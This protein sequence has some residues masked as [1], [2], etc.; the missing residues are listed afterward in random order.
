MRR[1]QLTTPVAVPQDGG[2]FHALFVVAGHVTVEAGSVTTDWPAGTSGL[3]PATAGGYRIMPIGGTA[4][5]LLTT[6]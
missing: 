4:V 5:V 1:V 2:S 3:V 6:L